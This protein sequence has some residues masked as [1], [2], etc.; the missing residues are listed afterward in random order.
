MKL[1]VF[2]SYG[3]L[4]HEKNPVY[5]VGRPASDIYDVVT[6]DIPESFPVWQNEAGSHIV[7]IDG[8]IYSLNEVLSNRG[9]RP[10]L[11]WYDGRSYRT[12]YL[13]K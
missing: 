9:D 1:N 11:S 13:D 2:K 7:S 3:V 5:T 12:V 6:V 8:E 4:A 10:V